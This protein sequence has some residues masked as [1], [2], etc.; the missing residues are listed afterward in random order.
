MGDN[1]PGTGVVGELNERFIVGVCENGQPA[2]GKWP[3]LSTGADG[4][5][6]CVNFG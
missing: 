3:F 2:A 5:E 6:E 1:S 4:I